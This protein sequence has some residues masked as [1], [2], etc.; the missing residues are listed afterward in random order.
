MIK[1][2]VAKKLLKQNHLL[3]LDGFSQSDI[4]AIFDNTDSMMEVLDRGIRKVPALRGKTVITLFSE[5]STRTRVSFEQAGKILSADVINVS[6]DGSSSK[7]GES[8]YNTALTLQAMKADAIVVRHQHSGAG[9]FLAQQMRSTSI[10]N[11]G[12][13]MHA[14]PTQSLLDLYTI[15]KHLGD[16]GSKRVVIVGDLLYS[17]VARSNLWGL[18]TMGADIVLCGPNTLLPQDFLDSRLDD[19][20][21]PFKNITIENDINKALSGANVVMALRLQSER[22]KAGHLP[23]LR[24]Y[25]RRFGI[26]SERLNLAHPEAIVMHPGPMN[27]GVEIE[28]DVAHG[29]QSVIES[30][31]TTG[32]AIRMAILYDL[33]TGNRP[34]KE[35]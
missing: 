2:T 31:V 10:I 8:L 26:N 23:S 3:D 21:H 20:R 16:I 11:A 35:L 24:E 25:S 5:A 13:G 4:Q 18:T 29:Q 1:D 12:D 32:V 14:H 28:P 9:Y 30:Q 17:R 34:E 27:E 15:K 6:S 19:V 33:I 22:Q 7:K